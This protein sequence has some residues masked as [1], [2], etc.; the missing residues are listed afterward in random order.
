MGGEGN[1][2][3]EPNDFDVDRISAHHLL[4]VRGSVRAVLFAA[5]VFSVGESNARGRDHDLQLWELM[6]VPA[7]A[8][9]DDRSLNDDPTHDAD[10]GW[11]TSSGCYI[12]ANPYDPLGGAG[13]GGWGGGSGGTGSSS[14]G[15]GPPLPPPAIPILLILDLD[16][17]ACAG[18][19][20]GN[21]APKFG[22]A[23]NNI[24]AFADGDAEVYSAASSIP[25]T[26]FETVNGDT[27]IGSSWVGGG[28]TI[29]YAA[30]LSPH[31]DPFTY[32]DDV[33]KTN[34]EAP[35]P[36]SALEWAILTYAHEITHQNGLGTTLNDE[37]KAE[38]YAY[39][40]L[41]EYRDD[42]GKKCL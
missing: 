13:G 10:G 9:T 38:S 23:M 6:T 33:S 15:S 39:G 34:R 4:D 41:K 40:V 25:P 3:F 28:T 26:G 12:W 14:G 18:I 7:R 35:G 19:A 29:L 1:R 32:Y 2:E 17:V 16:K 11:C 36:F 42:G 21:Q 24:W 31:R 22:F 8:G 5:L 20:Y 37:L 27:A 30:A